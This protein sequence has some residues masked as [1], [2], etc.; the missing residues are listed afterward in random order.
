MGEWTK[1]WNYAVSPIHRLT[2]SPI[3][4][5]FGASMPDSPILIAGAG[6]AGLTAAMTLAGAGLSV[7]VA[8]ARGTVG[9]RFIGGFQILENHSRP[10]DALSFLHAVGIDTNFW[11]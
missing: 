10:E 7:T 3:H 4:R 9:G 2:D 11:L 6:P 8:E 5:P 1:G